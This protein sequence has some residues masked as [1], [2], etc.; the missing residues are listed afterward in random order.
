[1]GLFDRFRRKSA[2]PEATQASGRTTPTFDAV[3]QVR[4][5]H[6]ATKHHPMRYARG[7]H[8]LNWETQPDPFRRYEGAELL[9]LSLNSPE[10]QLR[11]DDIVF[12]G[13]AEARQLDEQSLSELLRYAL[14]ISAWK[15]Y[16]DSRWSLRVNP[17]SGNLHPTEGY[18]LSGPVP[19]LCAEGFLA[20]YA[21]KEHGLEV[22]S[23]LPPEMWDDVSADLP[24][25]AFLIGLSS[26]LWREE[27]KYGE[28]AYRYCNHDVGHAIAAVAYSAA[29]LGWRVRMLDQ[30][31]SEQLAS[32]LG[33]S[34][35]GDAE[36][37]EADA[38][39]VVFPGEA[40]PS[41]QISAQFAERLGGLARSGSANQLSS[42]HLEWDAI[43]ACA[44]AS[45]KPVT[46]P[47]QASRSAR[48]A[49][50]GDAP[51]AVH[52]AE[53]FLQRRSAQNMDGKTSMAL[54][55]FLRTLQ[56]CMPEVGRIPFDSMPWQPRVH[57]AIFVHRVDGLE[58]G[59]YAL[60]REEAS[61]ARLREAMHAGFLWER[62]ELVPADLPLYLL[63]SGSYKS[64]AAGLS[65]DQAIAGESA[66]SL[67]M[68]AEFDQ[69]LRDH[70]GWFYPRLFWETGLIG[71]VLYL[72][73]EAANLRGTGI[74]C[75][76]D[77]PV[78]Q[79]LGLQGTAFQSLYHFTIGGAL[80]DK[81]L[82]T[83]APYGERESRGD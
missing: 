70:G 18:V 68:L 38:L 13:G 47:A 75:F 48:S 37:E 51:R 42:D 80:E 49:P 59:I 3:D 24:P 12:E 5:Y 30:I 81:R 83:L 76:H 7:P 74:G 67:G 79:Q 16:E 27:W 1:M 41:P 64:V 66:F 62:P 57:L 35:F 25:G 26:I 19:G 31:S 71:Q 77:D 11:F 8:G 39:L 56:R 20:H 61:G 50:I 55:D 33:L 28:R 14:G 40:Q 52:A 65:C 9:Q 2:P 23:T 69:A 58:P 36:P 6:H 21:P 29:R 10:K 22:R 54:A 46:V 44:F 17:S 34:D 73:A 53:L 72:E 63:K 43:Y 82:Q 15:E 45:E 60:L 4:R 32:V 78:H